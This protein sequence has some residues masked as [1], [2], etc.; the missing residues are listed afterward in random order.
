MRPIPLAAGLVAIVAVAAPAAAT[1]RETLL[2]AAF[3][4]PNKA[5]AIA[6]VQ[7]ALD[8]TQAMLA[9][10]PGDREARLQNALAIGYRGQ[11]KRTLTDAKTA[12]DAFVA[13]S[14]AYP[15][16]AEV[17][18]AYAGWHL[19]AVTDL[20]PFLARS[21]LGASKDQGLAAL[22]RS[23]ALGGNRAFFP[24]FAALIRVRLDPKD[25]RSPLT[26]ATTAMAAAT[27]TPLDKVMQRAAQRVSVP[28]RAGDGAAADKLAKQLLPFG[29]VS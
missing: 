18:V 12:R 5:Q 9:K 2:R 3:F 1:P 13:L 14:K 25:T 29:T 27:P 28:L 24:A 17:Q 6:L 20:G 21:V 10:T 22:Q 8:E 7:G 23:L 15:R 4:T 19:T 11:L 26:L 16:D